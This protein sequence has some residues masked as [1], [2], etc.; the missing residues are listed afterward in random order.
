MRVSMEFVTPEQVQGN[1]TLA[2][3]LAAAVAQHNGVV[4]QPAE[5]EKRGSKRGVGEARGRGNKIW[6]G[7]E[8]RV[9][10][11]GLLAGWGYPWCRG[12]GRQVA[13]RLPRR[14]PGVG[15]SIGVGTSCILCALCLCDARLAAPTDYGQEAA[16][17]YWWQAVRSDVACV[18]PAGRAAS[19]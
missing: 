6:L 11:V 16:F 19:P 15:R 9:C 12:V 1:G 14:A 10:P 3:A 17:Y 4:E 2:P 7:R 8:S 5:Q 13:G 18:L